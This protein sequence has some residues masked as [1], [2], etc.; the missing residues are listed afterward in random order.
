MPKK[1]CKYCKNFVSEY[2]KVPAGVF[3][4]MDHAVK[5][6]YEATKKKRAAVLLKAKKEFNKETKRLKDAAKTKGEWLKDCQTIFNRFIRLRDKDLNCISCGRYHSGQYHAGHYK[7][8]GSSPERL[9][10]NENN[11]HKQCAPC[12]NHLSGNITEYRINLIKKIGIEEVENLEGPHKSKKYT[13]DD[14]KELKQYYKNKVKQL[15]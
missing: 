12:N 1:K 6:A 5:F 13:I 4:G 7:S 9:R 2:I 15:Q 3:C 8:V 10:F 11:C 14:L